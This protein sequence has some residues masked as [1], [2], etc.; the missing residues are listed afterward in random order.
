MAAVEETQTRRLEV[1]VV[2]WM[3]VATAQ[4]RGRTADRRR[5]RR[6]RLFPRGDPRRGPR[7]LRRVAGRGLGDHARRGR[8]HPASV[9]KQSKFLIT[10]GALRH[11]RRNPGAQ[12]LQAD[13]DGFINS[14]YAHPEYIET[15]ATSQRR[16]V[17]MST[18]TSSCA[19]ARS[20]SSQLARNPQRRCSTA[21]SRS[22]PPHYA[23]CIECKLSGHRLR[24][25]G[26]RNAVSGPGD[27]GRLR[28][29][30]PQS[31]NR[32]C[33]GCFGPK[34]TPNT[35]SLGQWFEGMEMER[36]DVRDAFRMFCANAG[37]FRRAAEA[38]D[39]AIE[40]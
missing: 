34:E 3:S 22:M 25:G 17:T 10:I 27:P 36:R 14:V 11:R 35:A 1:L 13:I 37:A 12:E 26:A 32:G 31:F 19:A 2:R 9:R 39:A 30:V 5:R 15:L 38:L 20:T 8:A 18:W 24:D 40:E 6:D 16:C 21:A 28:Q 33:Y 23:Q 7:P 4:L 29:S